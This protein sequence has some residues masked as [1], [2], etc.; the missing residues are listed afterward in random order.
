MNILPYVTRKYRLKFL[1]LILLGRRYVLVIIDAVVLENSNMA[2][3]ASNLYLS[4]HTA[5][6]LGHWLLLW[7]DGGPRPQEQAA[8]LVAQ[9][10]ARVR[11]IG[12]GAMPYAMTPALTRRECSS[13]ASPSRPR[14]TA[15]FSA[16]SGPA[17]RWMEPGVACNCT[18]TPGC[19]I[20]P[21]SGCAI[22]TI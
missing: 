5:W 3:L 19:S 13:G 15:S 14:K 22:V 8:A 9:V 6:A 7:V 1:Y 10:V 16:P 11:F 21:S 20:M 4:V 18:V 17:R 12:P 2:Q